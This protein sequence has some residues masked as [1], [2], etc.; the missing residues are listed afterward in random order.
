MKYK[1]RI[2]KLIARQKA[3][4]SMDKKQGYKKPGSLSGR[5]S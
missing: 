2:N 3:Y 4:D 1:K 5:K